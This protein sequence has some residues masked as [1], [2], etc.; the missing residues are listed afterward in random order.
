MAAQRLRFV[1][2]IVSTA[3]GRA[4]ASGA[5][6]R[7]NVSS[8]SAGQES[9]VACTKRDAE[10]KRDHDF[11]NCRRRDVHRE[12]LAVVSKSMFAAGFKNP[13]RRTADEGR[14]VVYLWQRHSNKVNAIGQRGHGGGF[15]C[16]SMLGQL[17]RCF[18]QPA[19]SL[20]S[21]PS[22]ED[23]VVE[24]RVAHPGGK[25]GCVAVA[26]VAGPRR[27]VDSGCIS[28]VGIERK[29]FLLVE[30][31]VVEQLFFVAAIRIIESHGVKWARV[32][33]FAVSVVGR[34]AVVVRLRGI[35][36]RPTKRGAK[37]EKAQGRRNGAS[38]CAAFAVS[39]FR[40]R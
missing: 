34:R 33:G 32:A 29:D 18:F 36:L 30:G 19:P 5:S 11:Q 3:V 7:S 40:L 20:G 27:M 14:W 2:W 26:V 12:R 9:R 38:E 17:G 4:C 35:R 13:V 39:R 10:A 31:R 6:R 21:A 24:A 1:S 28:E 16:G 15:S 23:T 8:G 25:H 22:V 37:I